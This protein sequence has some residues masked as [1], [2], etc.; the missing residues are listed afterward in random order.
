MKMIITIIN[1][2]SNNICRRYKSVYSN[3]LLVFKTENLNAD[4]KLKISFVNQ[5][6]LCFNYN[7]YFLKKVAKLI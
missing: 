7:I 3:N 4:K 5:F 2:N 6:G 1:D